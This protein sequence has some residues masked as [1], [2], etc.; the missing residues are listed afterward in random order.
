MNGERVGTWYTNRSGV[1]VFQYEDAWLDSEYRRALSLSLPILP[2]NEPHVGDAVASWFEN[3][4][5]ESRTI[6]DRLRRRFG[7]A[8]AGAFDLLAAIGRDCVGAV[9]L[10]PADMDPGDVRRVGASAMDDEEV[11]RHLRSVTVPGPSGSH[12]ED[13][14]RFSLAGAQ[15]K[16]ALL[17]IDGK[18]HRPRG[19]TPST[20]ILKLPLGIV[21]H[22]RADMH[23]SVEN[24]W[25][26][27]Q[28]LGELELPVAETELATFH[29]EV[30]LERA[31]VVT[32][33]DRA[34]TSASSRSKKKWVARLPQEDFCQA[35]AVPAALKYESDGGPGIR[36][37]LELVRGGANP[38]GDARTFVL[39]QLAFWLLA[40]TDGHAK[41]F[42]VF[43]RR[44][45]YTM[46]PLYDVLSAWPIIGHGPR[47]LPLRKATLAM[48]L[49]GTRATR[50]HLEEI[51]VRHWQGLALRSG[52]S[53]G[54]EDMV[55]LVERSESA[56]AS[57]GE[58][59]PDGFPEHVWK[60]IAQGVR[61]QRR[62]FLDALARVS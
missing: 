48:A 57:L 36:K 54:F 44:D 52:L 25:L 23:D 11:A 45:G 12:D 19:A 32:R 14:F 35:S 40:A 5:P 29:D 2:G 18:W 20:H 4:L 49:R 1:D 50:R 6:R 60:S 47:L 3:L 9:Q 55:A 24:E 61:S 8:S 58:R 7:A 59:L 17:R 15:E 42:A 28:F 16:T 51:S 46:T 30:S 43:L 21:G 31:L 39:A 41:N 34:W 53:D 62:R 33:F 26:C 38:D 22:M 13:D 10:V 56:L 37:S 27:M